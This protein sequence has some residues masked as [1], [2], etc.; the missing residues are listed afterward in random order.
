M[1]TLSDLEKL[2]YREALVVLVDAGYQHL[3]TGDWSVVFAA[4]TSDQVVKISPFDPAFLEFAH[5]CWERPHHYLPRIESIGRLKRSGFIVTMP[6]YERRPSEAAIF[7]NRL[8]AVAEGAPAKEL[9][10]LWEILQKGLTRC[11]SIP[12]FQGV[13][14]NPEN[15]LFEGDTPK[16]VDPYNVSGSTIAGCLRRGEPVELHEQAIE[17]FL[18]IPFHSPVN[19]DDR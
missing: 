7:L 8:K 14:W 18:S 3:A 2:T 10:D 4:T 16:F 12:Y 11:A 13:D 5:M 15:V 1:A 17:D 6:R 19:L 9:E